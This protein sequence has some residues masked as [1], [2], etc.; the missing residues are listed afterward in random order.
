MI[1][2]RTA[3]ISTKSICQFLGMALLVLVLGSCRAQSIE[4]SIEQ[5]TDIQ[6]EALLPG[7]R[8]LVKESSEH[9]R[10]MSFNVG[11]DSI[12]SDDDHQ[13][14]QL[15]QDSTGAE[16][17]RI[18]KAIKPDIICLQEINPIRDPQQVGDILNDILP[19][20][21]DMGWRTH[22]GQDNV[23][24][25]RFDLTR[26]TDELVYRGNIVNFGHAMALVDLPDNQY[27]NDLYLICAH[28]KAQGGQASI[29]ARQKHA[30]VIVSWVGDAKTPG[31]EIDLPF[32]TP[33]VVLGDFNVYDTEPANHLTTLLNG[34]IVNE[35]RYGQDIFP[36]WDETD[37][38]DALPRHNGEGEEIYTW[39]DDTQ[40]FNP[41]ALDRILYTDSV[42]LIEN[43]F[44][45]NTTLL[46]E[47]ELEA[48]GLKMGD[49]MLDPETGR[50]DH[51]P[52]S[53][54]ISFRD[55]TLGQ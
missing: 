16:F 22:G 12:F 10:I 53:I 3:F 48:T 51:L 5:S 39:R 13:N 2:N 38:T 43:G 37:L 21:D 18:L 54:D 31:G 42:I 30:D 29:E 44:V 32:G 6:S 4:Q 23:I 46:T 15:R 34:D 9:I 50:Y 35:D 40:E 1:F 20:E 47:E 28:F 41:G 7:I 25:T 52:L 11:F 45:L 27:E 26:E 8:F 36:D 33:L 24:A 17:A 14:H 19:L 55:L 49:V